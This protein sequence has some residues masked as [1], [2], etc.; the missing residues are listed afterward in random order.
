MKK[1]FTI[2]EIVVVI[3]VI[4]FMLPMFIS[5]FFN[6]TRLQMQLLITQQL[7]EEGDYV[8]NQIIN[9]VR[10]SATLI[11]STCAGLSL[12]PADQTVLCFYDSNSTPFGYAVDA[13]ANVASYSA[14]LASPLQ[15]LRSNTDKDI[16]IRIMFPSFSIIDSRTAQFKYTVVYTPRVNYLPEQSMVYQFYTYLRN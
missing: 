10:N 14:A 2:I 8:Q 13:S 16:P 6:I 12:I 1:A 5:I 15:L 3:A 9:T 7:K 4:G 11:N